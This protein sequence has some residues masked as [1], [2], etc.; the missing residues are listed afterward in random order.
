MRVL[1]IGCFDLL[2][3]GHIRHLARASVLGIL[4][5]GIYSNEVIASYKPPPAMSLYTRMAVVSSLRMV[6]MVIQ[7]NTRDIKAILRAVKPDILAVGSEWGSLKAHKAVEKKFKVVRIPY[8]HGVSSS[9]I[10]SNI[11]C[12]ERAYS[13][14]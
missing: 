1:T 9:L 2:H 4:T 3:E 5:V 7:L 14:R 13:G 6:D 8:T 12:L 11:A 10:R